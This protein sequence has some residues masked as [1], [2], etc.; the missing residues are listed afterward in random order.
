MNATADTADA[1]AQES[2]WSSRH[3][4]PRPPARPR[5]GSATISASRGSDNATLAA[6][7]ANGPHH[8]FGPLR[9][10]LTQLVRL[11]GPEPDSA[12]PGRSSRVGP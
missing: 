9:V 11:A 5:N 7:L 8:W 2:F 6:S 12:V 10:P 3:A 4:P 1:D